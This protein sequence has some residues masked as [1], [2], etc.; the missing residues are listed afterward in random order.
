MLVWYIT[1]QHFALLIFGAGVGVS[2]SCYLNPFSEYRGGWGRNGV[3]SLAG[4]GEGGVGD[5]PG[6]RLHIQPKIKSFAGTDS[7]SN[8]LHNSA[9]IYL[10]TN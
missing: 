2:G 3:P 1:A 7:D 10:C 9:T 5:G 8:Y 6:G 4:G